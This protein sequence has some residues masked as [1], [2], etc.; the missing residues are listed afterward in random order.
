MLNPSI[1]TG[2]QTFFVS[3]QEVAS[4]ITGE[5]LRL[6]LFLRREYSI[7]SP[8]VV[9][10]G[11]GSRVIINSVW[12]EEE[13]VEIVDYDPVKNIVLAI[14]RSEPHEETPLHWMIH[15]A[16]EDV[17]VIAHILDSEIAKSLKRGVS[18]T[19]EIKK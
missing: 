3:R 19:G 15:R 11:F 8:I 16:R 4:P 13:F 14:G 5:L 1:F 12:S 2:F 6:R 10:I 17:H 18:S 7:M 9:S